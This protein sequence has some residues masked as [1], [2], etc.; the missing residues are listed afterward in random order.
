MLDGIGGGGGGGGGGLGMEVSARDDLGGVHDEVALGPGPS[1]DRDSLAHGVERYLR[2]ARSPVRLVELQVDGR[3]QGGG[4]VERRPGAGLA[5]RGPH[6]LI[7]FLGA[8]G[9]DGARRRPALLFEHGQGGVTSPDREIRIG[10]RGT[11]AAGHRRRC[12]FE[13]RRPRG[14]EGR[15]YAA[16]LR[17]DA[18]RVALRVHAEAGAP[19]GRGVVG[20]GE[21]AR[22]GIS[23][24]DDL[25]ALAP[26]EHVAQGRRG[27]V[28]PT[29]SSSTPVLPV[30]PSWRLL[31]CHVVWL[32][33][34]KALTIS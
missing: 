25:A 2:P 13:R 27:C 5:N 8:S 28:V 20:V 7:V 22:R 6:D 1:P 15:P 3:G 34:L 10:A 21:A 19:G 33:D 14:R 18:Q 30:K 12:G 11:G 24:G 31:T 17:P 23:N 4:S 9:A 16:A 26:G 32:P 29:A